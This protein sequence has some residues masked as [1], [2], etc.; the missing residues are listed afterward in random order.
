MRLDLLLIV[1]TLYYR[2][3][4]D[5]YSLFFTTNSLKIGLSF[6][7]GNIVA[8][9]IENNETSVL[10]SKEQLKNISSS[11]QTQHDNNFFLYKYREILLATSNLLRSYS[12]S[13]KTYLTLFILQAQHLLASLPTEHCNCSILTRK[14][15]GKSHLL[16]HT[17]CLTSVQIR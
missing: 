13:K 4:Q 5:R 1:I 12:T 11:G 16:L 3:Y 14:R 8:W 6:Q 2:F 10:V 9:N 7:E 15:S 17:F